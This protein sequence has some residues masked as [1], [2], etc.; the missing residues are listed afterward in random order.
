MPRPLQPQPGQK[1][2]AVI[3][4]SPIRTKFGNKSVRAHDQQGWFVYPVNPTADDIEGWTAYR[5]ISD[6]PVDRVDRVTMYVPPA[7]G[8]LL[9]EEIASKKPAEVWL[10]PGTESDALLQRAEQL[11]LPVIQACSIVD[12]GTT[13]AAFTD[14]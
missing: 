5:S 14:H 6:V 1:T 10:N 9:L 3:G 7:V 8:I 4:A 2:V 11:Q 13:P 12:L